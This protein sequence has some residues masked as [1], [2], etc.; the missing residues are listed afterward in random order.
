M[1]IYF[2]A[3]AFADQA[4]R[5]KHSNL[6]FLGA[7][8]VPKFEWHSPEVVK[9][10]RLSLPVVLT[11]TS[12]TPGNI[13][14]TEWFAKEAAIESSNFN[15]KFANGSQIRYAKVLLNGNVFDKN[16]GQFDLM[17]DT[18]PKLTA[19]TAHEFLQAI[20]TPKNQRHERYYMQESMDPSFAS[21]IG[22]A[23]RNVIQQL[24][25][26]FI[27][28]LLNPLLKHREKLLDKHTVRE[29][30]EMNLWMGE[31]GTRTPLHFDN[32]HNFFYQADGVKQVYL[33]DP[34]YGSRC[35]GLFVNVESFFCAQHFVKFCERLPGCMNFR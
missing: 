33:F 19:M 22:A 10:L 32:S 28:S 11:N 26:Q 18:Y 8:H 13:W 24:D 3:F 20:T 27:P 21:R 7:K 15:V 17:T 29:D 14:N 12:L 31:G 5:P 23:H 1:C 35:T 9:R 2:T 34:T 4:Y 16:E 30:A 6:A 25:L